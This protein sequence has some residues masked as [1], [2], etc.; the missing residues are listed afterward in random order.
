MMLP[1]KGVNMK[2]HEKGSKKHITTIDRFKILKYLSL[3]YNIPKIAYLLGY[4]KTSIYRELIL[5]SVVENK[6][7]NT[8]QIGQ[9]RN[10]KNAQTCLSN[11]IKKCSKTCMKYM[12][13]TCSL[14]K[15]PYEICNFC[16]RKN[17]CKHER[18][19]YHPE[20][21]QDTAK[22]R[23]RNGKTKI[24]LDD[25]E[26]RLFDDYVSS[27]IINGQSPEVVKSY[28]SDV[29]FP[30]C[31]R[32]LRNYIDKGL[33]TAKNIDLRRKLSLTVSKNYNYPRT[34]SHNPLRKINHLYDD[35]LDYIRD[36]PNLVTFQCDTVFGKR[37]DK[38]CL[39]TIHADKLHFQM[40]ILLTNKTAV[41]VNQ[42]F[43]S[44]INRL[45][46]E[47]FS[48]VF[49]VLLSD[50]G[51]EFDDLLSL[52]TDENGVVLC[53]VFFTRAYRSSDKAECER[54]HE[55]FRFIKKKGKTLD[56][57]EEEDIELINSNINS[58]PRKSL[59][60]KTPIEA[61]K[62]RF[63]NDIVSLLGI[64]EIKRKDVNLTAR[65]LHHK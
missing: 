19:I 38:K 48:K 52:E 35:Y 49:E 45:G 4:N 43:K 44:I 41:R 36:H 25:D 63:G 42:A 6:R 9:L 32:T 34:Y 14:I 3:G 62:D 13:K 50:N 16:E 10:C 37:N 60:W 56:T 23:F 64:E 58:Y 59:S 57:L 65:L 12:A 51:S 7:P 40:Y 17:G 15:K 2:K 24:K 54:N 5:N 11:G 8:H 31:S 33:L 21:A 47:R 26:L 55:L 46:K 20:I 18:L 53:H 29:N 28:S 61:M 39:L 30:V 22:D 27:L 1:K